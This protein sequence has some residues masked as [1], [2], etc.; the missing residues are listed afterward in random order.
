MGADTRLEKNIDERVK[1]GTG[2]VSQTSALLKQVS[3][4][5]YYMEIGLLYRESYM[6]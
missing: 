4:G 3:L 5:F 1:K 6:F 2:I